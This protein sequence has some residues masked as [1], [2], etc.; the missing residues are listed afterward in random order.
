MNLELVANTIRILSADG[1]QKAKSGHPGLPMGMADF[2]SVLYLKH[3]KHDPKN[4]D[5]QDRDRF[6]LSAGHG[7]MLLYSVLHL[8]GYDVSI[9]DLKK[10]RQLDSRTPGHPEY[11]VTPGVE[12]STGP[13]G[14]GCG[15]GVGMA[16]AEA[17]LAERFN[18]ESEKIV[19]HYTYVLCSDGEMME[20]ISHEALAFA[21]HLK[22]NKLILF[23]DYNNI[24]IEGATDLT[25]SE[26]VR[27]RFESYGWNVLEVDAHNF[28]EID[29]A[30]CKAKQ[31]QNA[32]TIIIGRSIIGKGSP[33]MAGTSEVHGAPLGDDELKA[34]K[35]NLGFDEN[36]SFVV[37]EE[38]RS[39]FAAR[40]KELAAQ[41]DAWNETLKRYRAD[42][43]EKAEAWDKYQGNSV[44][45]NIESF[46]PVFDLEKP[47]ATRSA[48]GKVIQSM[49]KA[50]CNLVGGSADLAPSTKTFINGES[51]VGP[52]SFSGKNFHFGIREHG[53]GAI[54]NGMALHGSFKV[55][56]STFLVFSDYCRPAIRLAALMKLPVIYIFTHDSIYVGEDGPTHEPVEHAASLRA[57]PGLTVIRPAD[58][59]ETG[60]AWKVALENNDG[61]TAI[62]LTR[63]DI[64]VL[65]RNKFASASG[66]E[67]GG[68]VIWDSS[69][70]EPDVIII[71]SGSEVMTSLKAAEQLVASN[72]NVR[73]VSMPSWELFEEQ[74]EEY[75]RSVLPESCP[76]RLAVEAGIPMGWEK[77]V[78]DN[79]RILGL[80]EF[81]A[82][83]P[84]KVLAEKYGFTPENVVKIVNE[85]F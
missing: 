37:P 45:E 42:N 30:L 53:M 74:S 15:N 72:K 59:T 50:V 5:W 52:G 83:A 85:N 66:L 4:P 48:S 11:G 3:L 47:I 20:G 51:A 78:G 39:I 22:L 71:A 61:P 6:V 17:M 65:D 55:F 32:P 57:I 76:R 77:Y 63:H 73:V 33:K 81:G 40:A 29:N 34:T 21:G 60:I 49:A 12:T 23:Y 43:P 67:R 75:K 2:A 80:N 44:P 38:V 35:R 14:Q 24:T 27:M 1:I 41:H 18:T 19:D 10:F 58:A 62:L 56:G 82:S 46:L 16:I 36:E 13:L 31:E 54:L 69:T 25:Y 84:Y 64:P 79:G 7:A 26:D 9:D 28:E 70:S 68:Y 8:A